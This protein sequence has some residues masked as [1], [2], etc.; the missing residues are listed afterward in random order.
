MSLLISETFDV[1]VLRLSEPISEF[2]DS[3][4]P[5]CL[6]DLSASRLNAGTK[7]VVTGWGAI[8]FE[9]PGSKILKKVVI[10]TINFISVC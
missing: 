4:R 2:T 3:I 5:V 9:G 10:H 1:A 7:V 8:S 6:P